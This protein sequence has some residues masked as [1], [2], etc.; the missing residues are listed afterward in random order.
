[1]SEL[2]VFVLLQETGANWMPQY[3]AKFF[4]FT[5]QEAID[6]VALDPI[7]R[8]WEELKEY[9]KCISNQKESESSS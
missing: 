8:D 4:V 6:W 7:S 2:T 1:M 5:E 3:D 9:D